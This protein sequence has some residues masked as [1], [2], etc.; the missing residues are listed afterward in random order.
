MALT[1]DQ[2]QEQCA[3]WLR[4]AFPVGGPVLWHH[5]PNEG[6]HKVQYHVKQNRMGRRKGWADL[7]FVWAETWIEA[8]PPGMWRSPIHLSPH[9]AFAELKTAT[10][11][12]SSAQRG[13]RDWCKVMNAPWE[14]CRSVEDL[15]AFLRGIPGFP[16]PRGERQ[17]A[18]A[19][20]R[21][22]PDEERRT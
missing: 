19:T 13:I 3:N 10:G 17:T 4:V 1:E 22:R 18:V 5:S 15:Q 6:K 2:I 21:K 11:R 9:I 7:E 8:I 14:L 12:L 20:A 16:A